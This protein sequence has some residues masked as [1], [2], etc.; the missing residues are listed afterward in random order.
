MAQATYQITLRLDGNHAVSVSG[1]DPVA[2]QD[3]L[4]W[5]R[6]IHLKL[7]AHDVQQAGGALDDEPPS[8][9]V[10]DVAMVQV[11]GK[12]GPFWSCHEKND[13]GS[14]CSYKPQSRSGVDGAALR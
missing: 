9:V 10:H 6:G 13:D 14:W 2:M 7:T 4:A 11:Q 12:K 3:G 8:C 1:D 5:A